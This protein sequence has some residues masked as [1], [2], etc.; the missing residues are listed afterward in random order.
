MVVQGILV[1]LIAAYGRIEQAWLGQQMIARPIWL[2]ALVGFVLGDFTKGLMIG[3]ALELIWMGVVQI[4]ATPAEVVSGS[5]ISSALV[6]HNGMPVEEA[7]TIA[8]P[9]A[10]LAT[11]LGTVITTVN[12]LLWTPI[13]ESAVKKADLKTIFWVGMAGGGTLAVVYFIIVFAAYTLGSGAVDTVVNSIPV[14]IRTG[15]SNAAGLL[16]AIGIATLLKFTWNIKF[17]GFFFLG[18]FL[19][20]YLGISSMGIAIAGA[21]CAFIYYQMKPAEVEED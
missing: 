7:V 20:S 6:I 9:V 5:V 2:C 18:F 10:L 3:G 1:G 14:I 12:S 15:L 19:A 21:V 11:I 17:A 4:G 16:P 13:A 8:I